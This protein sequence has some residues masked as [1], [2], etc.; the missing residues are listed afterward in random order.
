MVDDGED[1]CLTEYDM[2]DF[3]HHIV[4]VLA[5]DAERARLKEGALRKAVLMSAETMASRLEIKYKEL[6]DLY[7]SSASSA[8]I[9]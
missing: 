4:R 8:D 9:S 3:V 1:G 2:D 7:H 5:D 6:V